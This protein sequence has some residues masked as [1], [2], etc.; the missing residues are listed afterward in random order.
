MSMSLST[1][2]T[3]PVFPLPLPPSQPQPHAIIQFHR[4]Q[5]PLKSSSLQLHLQ[6]SSD[7]DALLPAAVSIPS[8]SASASPSPSPSASSWI[9]SLRSKT[10]S[11][12]FK[13]AVSTYICMTTAG[14]PPD[15]FA[16]PAVLKA[17]A[18][19]QDL[20]LGKQLHAQALKL[21]YASSSVTVS[22]TLIHFYGKCGDIGDASQAFDRISNRDQVSWNSMIAAACRFEDWGLAIQ[23]FRLRNGHSETFTVNALIAMYAKLGRVDDCIALFKSFEDRDLVSWNTV[24]SSL[25]QN[26]RYLE[27]LLC[28]HHMVLDGTKPDAVTIASI[29]PACSQLQMFDK[30]REIHAQALKDEEIIQNSFVASALVDMYSNCRRVDSARHIFDSTSDRK[31]GLWNAMIAGYA[32]NEHEHDALKFFIEMETVA[33]LHSNATTMASVLPAC[34]C[35]EAFSVKESIHGHVVKKGLERD[36]YVQNALMDMYARMGRLDIAE[37]IFE[38]MQVKD[39]VSWNTMI[40]AYVLREC[41]DKA[42][43]LLSQIQVVEEDANFK[44]KDCDGE[45]VNPRANGVTLMTVLPG[46]AALAA[47]SKGKEIHGYAIRSMLASDV[48]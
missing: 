39:I 38:E 47:L 17:A 19:L 10:R 30:G 20:H 21:G 45:R 46:C 13:E 11:N 7:T 28:L 31:I 3:V 24:I 40:T 29:L 15:N 34:V 48:A 44:E 25:S 22:N 35:S 9:E 16:F 6:T 37:A 26:K 2:T 12:L 27:A 14:I 43:F 4:S 8:P 36:R 1:S 18:A 42:L 41:H 33:G 5:R 23:L 32:Q